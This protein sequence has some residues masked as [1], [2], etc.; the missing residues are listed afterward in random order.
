MWIGIASAILFFGLIWIIIKRND[1]LLSEEIG[2]QKEI[3]KS[4]KTSEKAN[5]VRKKLNKLNDLRKRERL[6]NK[7]S[8]Q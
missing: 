4:I 2:K 5:A 7:W 6:R 8:K 1:G 3:I